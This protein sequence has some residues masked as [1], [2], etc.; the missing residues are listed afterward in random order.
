MIK[1][2]FFVEIEMLKYFIHIFI[3]DIPLLSE[4]IIEKVYLSSFLHLNN[5]H[6]I[7]QYIL[8][9]IKENRNNISLIKS[10][11]YGLINPNFLF[12]LYLQLNFRRYHK[13]FL[14]ILKKLFLILF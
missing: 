13:T 5:E 10:I 1:T 9:K 7:F 2:I 14:N 8:N 4:L 3:E 6:E 12:N 11:Y